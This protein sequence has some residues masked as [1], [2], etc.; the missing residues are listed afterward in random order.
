[1]KSIY[2]QKS[3]ALQ[4]VS[5]Q[6]AASVIDASSQSE[7]LQ[8][9]VDCVNASSPGTTIQMARGEF[10]RS[11]DFQGNERTPVTRINPERLEMLLK[12]TTSSRGELGRTA[13]TLL[14][15]GC[16]ILA[17]LHEGGIGG[18][19]RGADPSRHITVRSGGYTYHIKVNTK[20]V[21]TDITR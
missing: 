21:V 20:G 16:V 19:G 10:T 1:M 11:G 8:R 7:S 12:N 2:V 17:G 15:Q 3:F 4:K 9:K 18:Q 6:N 5:A 13:K 14:K